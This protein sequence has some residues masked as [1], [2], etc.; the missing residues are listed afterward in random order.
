MSVSE[1]D[2]TSV[3]HPLLAAA[4]AALEKAEV[5]WCLLRWPQNPAAPTGDVDLLLA[6]DD[7]ERARKQLA[8]LGL[9]RVPAVGSGYEYVFL[10]YH[11]ATDCWIRLHVVTA[12]AFGPRHRWHSGVEKACLA[13]RVRRETQTELAAEDA[14]WTTLLHCLLDKNRITEHRREDLRRTVQASDPSGPLRAVVERMCPPGWNAARLIEAVRRGAWDELTH[15]AP[16]L[17]KTWR[18]RTPPLVRLARRVR[19]GFRLPRR[20]LHAWRRR[21]LSVA[22]LG[23]DGAGKSTLA[24]GLAHSFFAPARTIYMG[25]GISGGASRPALLAR[26]TLPGLGAPGRLFVLW[27]RLAAARYHQ[28]R[29]RLVLFDRYTYDGLAPP[30]GRRRLSSWIKARACPAPDAVLLLDVP[31][32]V[33]FQRKGDLDVETL[34]FQRQRFLALCPRLP[35]VLVVDGTRSAEVVRIAA[36]EYIWQRYAARWQKE[37]APNDKSARGKP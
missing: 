26:W 19:E 30:P 27:A 31:G 7:L 18:Q 5:C 6:A 24:A 29:G 21:G 9:V 23:P 32:S 33:M 13:R 16:L 22:I 28:M 11:A 36:L 3:W 8:S 4:F 1:D 17:A 37:S 35:A 25:F 2:A 12:L 10:A 34:E 15:F 14:F 20:L